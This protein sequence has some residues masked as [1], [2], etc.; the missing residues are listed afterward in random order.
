M[1]FGV[2]TLAVDC[3]QLSRGMTTAVRT[4][5]PSPASVS[6]GGGGWYAS[7]VLTSAITIGS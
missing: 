6:P 4:L 7:F 2:G 1:L 5:A 3:V